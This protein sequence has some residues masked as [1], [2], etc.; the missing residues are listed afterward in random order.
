[1]KLCKNCN[2]F[3]YSDLETPHFRCSKVSTNDFILGRTDGF[4]IGCTE[5][6]NNSNFCGFEA[7]WYEDKNNYPYENH[8]D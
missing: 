5:L 4:V 7:K 2:F 8:I 1:M 6:R 3:N